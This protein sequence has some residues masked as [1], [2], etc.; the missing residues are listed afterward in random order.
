[1]KAEYSPPDTASADDW[2]RHWRDFADLA[3]ESPAKAF[4]HR[5]VVEALHE[6]GG[7]ERLLDV[8]SG[9]GDLAARI[10]AA[11]PD[12]DILGLEL[13]RV[14]VAL[15]QARVPD[16]TFVTRDLLVESEVEP[17]HRGWATHAVC[18]EVLEHVDHPDALLR[19]VQPYFAPG[20]RL[21]VTVPGG[22]I[23]AFD[24]HIGHR[25][26]F[27]AEDLADLLEQAGFA[28]ESVRC[29]GFPF[30]NLYRL[31]VVARGRR[32]AS[33]VAHLEGS[34]RVTARVAMRTAGFL[35]RFN[36]SNSRRGWQLV[37]SAVLRRG[38]PAAAFDQAI[39][40]RQA[41][42]SSGSGKPLVGSDGANAGQDTSAAAPG[43]SGRLRPPR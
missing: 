43:V 22:P 21:I 14:G 2:D 42:P 28:V 8:G 40:A 39:A 20:C 34:P 27:T 5:L 36:R 11:F 32:L 33:D 31:A 13:S 38:Y 3:A 25:R 12:A 7:P 24:R 26:H 4:R 29:A 9:A 23:S 41:R 18:S 30:F 19:A 10:R 17:G 6:Q 15:S 37:A 35:L 1:M 16:A